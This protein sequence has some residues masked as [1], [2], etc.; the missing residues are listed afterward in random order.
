MP[1]HTRFRFPV[2]AKDIED[3]VMLWSPGN[4]RV[5]CELSSR[6]LGPATTVLSH[7]LLKVLLLT[8]TSFIPCTTYI[9]SL[10]VL[11]GYKNWTILFLL[12]S[13]INAQDFFWDLTLWTG[14]AVQGSNFLKFII[15][16]LVIQIINNSKTYKFVIC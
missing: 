15:I 3:Q 11:D 10:P 4:S 14:T 2:E 8:A 5:L 9:S 6:P 1:R 13:P 7:I 12:I 16:L